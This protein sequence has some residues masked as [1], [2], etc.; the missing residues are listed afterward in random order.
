MIPSM[1]PK[2]SIIDIWQGSKLPLQLTKE[3][4]GGLISNQTNFGKFLMKRLCLTLPFYHQLILVWFAVTAQKMKFSIEN[5]ISQCDQV[6]LT[7]FVSFTDK[8][9]HG[10]LHCWCHRSSYWLQIE[11]F[12]FFKIFHYGGP[13]HIETSP[14]IC[15]ANQWT[16]FYMIR[17]SVMKELNFER[18]ILVL[19]FRFKLIHI[20][21]IPCVAHVISTLVHSSA[22]IHYVSSIFV[23]HV[24]DGI[25]LSTPYVFINRWP[26]TVKQVMVRW[27][28]HNKKLEFYTLPKNEVFRWGFLW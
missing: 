14:L 27:C 13:Y 2:G 25:I 28:Y 21:K 19:S 17:T 3:L 8:I 5:S 7:N 16:G 23:T 9:L 18:Q 4:L 20:W 26:D 12:N 24:G 10:K 22:A 1:I 11:F 6:F 15:R